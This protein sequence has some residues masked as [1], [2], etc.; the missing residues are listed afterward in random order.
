MATPYELQLANAALQQRRAQYLDIV[1]REAESAGIPWQLLDAIIVRESGYRPDAQS[2]LPR[3]PAQGLGQL[4]TPAAIDA[5]IDPSKRLDPETNIRGSANYL[6]QMYRRAGGD[7]GRAGAAYNI[8]PTSFFRDPNDE[9]RG[10]DDYRGWME[11][12]QAY[13]EGAPAE[14]SNPTL[15]QSLASTFAPLAALI[16]ELPSTPQQAAPTVL[17]STLQQTVSTVLPST[18]QQA[19]PPSANPSFT[20]SLASAFAPLAALVPAPVRELAPIAVDAYQQL[21]ALPEPVAAPVA[22]VPFAAAI[23]PGPPAQPMPEIAPFDVAAGTLAPRPT[24]RG[25]MS[26][27]EVLRYANYQPSYRLST[28]R[29]PG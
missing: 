3:D 23:Q 12:A 13:A 25:G 19:T 14:L 28:G 18:L 22:S 20:Q 29:R 1:Q 17:P 2:N 4:R 27:A 5:G 26:L 10:E 21:T 16:P 11:A 9:R 6:A 24:Q 7:W 15:A 8:G